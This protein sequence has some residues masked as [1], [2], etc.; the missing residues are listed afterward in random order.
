MNTYFRLQFLGLFLLTFQLSPVSAWASLGQNAQSIISDGTPTGTLQNSPIPSIK[1]QTVTDVNGTQITEFLSNGTVFGLTW[2]GHQIP[3][4]TQIFTPTYS[5]L[6]QTQLPS[7]KPGHLHSPIAVTHTQ[8]VVHIYGHM[9]YS[10][11]SAYLPTHIPH[12][13]TLSVLGIAQ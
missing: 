12:G 1:E 7:L 11:G 6:F 2:S 3:N 9:G 4:F 10:A 13:I 5:Q 8:L